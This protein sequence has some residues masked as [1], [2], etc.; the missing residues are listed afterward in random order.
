[1]PIPNSQVFLRDPGKDNNQTLP[2]GG[3]D[4]TNQF[5]DSRQTAAVP[6]AL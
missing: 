6:D 5:L 3:G 2:G 1:M 4:R